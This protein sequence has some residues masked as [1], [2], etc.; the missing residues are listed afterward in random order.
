MI[1]CDIL[2]D[3]QAKDRGYP[4][5]PIEATIHQGRRRRAESSG[6]TGRNVT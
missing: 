3:R 1:A 6:D 2:S 5:P 4:F